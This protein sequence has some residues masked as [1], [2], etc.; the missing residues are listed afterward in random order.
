LI[1]VY[2]QSLRQLNS[3]KAHNSTV[4]R[5][6][7]SPLN[8]HLVATCSWDLTV[9]I[10][11][12]SNV[13]N[14]TLIRAYT[15]HSNF[16]WGL[17]WISEEMIASGSQDSIIKI[18]SIKTAQTNRTIN[19]GSGVFSLKLLSNGFS[20]AS[21]LGNGKIRIFNLNDENKIMTLVGHTNNVFD[22]V[23]ISSDLM[24]SS[25]Y[26]KNVFIWNLTT[27][28]TKFI[29]KG[30][31]DDVYGLKLVSSEILASGSW[32]K[33]IKFWNFTNG[34]LI[35]TLTGHTS[36]LH[37]SIDLLEENSLTIVSGSLD[38]TIKTWNYETG[39]YIKTFSTEME[40]RILTLLNFSTVGTTT[41]TASSKDFD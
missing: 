1:K 14:W 39:E 40:I 37:W 31:T 24:A 18:W 35:R 26:D 19:A 34:T 25:G 28:S 21:G 33:S 23:E 12:V 36:F 3:F 15:G 29:L 11:N 6:I 7:Q 2:N 22:L 5:I 30:H 10:W 16:V 20:L 41:L 8:N 38:Q 9:K 32:D 27:N 4:N 13:S 17:E